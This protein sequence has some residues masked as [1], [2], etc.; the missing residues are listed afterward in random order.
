MTTDSIKWGETYDL[1]V[2]AQDENGDA[3]TIDETWSAACRFVSSADTATT[4]FQGDMTIADNAASISIDTGEAP[5][6]AG[7]FFYDVRFTDPDGNDY[8]TESIRLT[9][10]TRQTPAS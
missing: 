8:W 5:W 4:I 6:K 7:T 3:V 2:S 1:S 10:H 9:L